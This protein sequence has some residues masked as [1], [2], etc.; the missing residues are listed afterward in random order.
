MHF[1]TLTVTSFSSELRVLLAAGSVE[2][3]MVYL[4]PLANGLYPRV[5]TTLHNGLSLWLSQKLRVVLSVDK[6]DVSFCL[7]LTDELGIGLP[8]GNFSELWRCLPSI[9][10]SP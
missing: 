9:E 8:L 2:P 3:I 5:V 10:E 7:G 1:P 6:Q 4:R